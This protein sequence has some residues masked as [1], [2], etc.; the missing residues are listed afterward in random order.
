MIETTFIE[1]VD[2]STASLQS[3]DYNTLPDCG[4]GEN[5]ETVKK[6]RKKKKE[7]KSSSRRQPGNEKKRFLFITNE[8]FFCIR[9]IM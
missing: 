9:I 5:P 4:L 1:S 3:F 8:N 6:K 7:A 2:F